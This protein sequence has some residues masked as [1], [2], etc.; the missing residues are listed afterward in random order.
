[1]DV[2]GLSWTLETQITGSVSPTISVVEE[3]LR[4]YSRGFSE[5]TKRAR[6]ADLR[7]YRR[8]CQKKGFV[9]IPASPEQIESFLWD[10]VATQELDDRDQPRFKK[11]GNPALV[12]IRSVATIERYLS[13]IKYLHDL[14]SEIQNEFTN[15]VP[16]TEIK[17]PVDSLLVKSAL[18]AIKREFRL[19]PQ[20]QAAPL[21]LEHIQTISEVLDTKGSLR[22][23]LYMTLISVAFDTLVRRSE[24]VRMELEHVTMNSAGDGVVKI[25]FSKTDQEGNGGVRYLSAASIELI[26][27]WCSAAGIESGLIFRSV[28]RYG[29]KS[30]KPDE[31]TKDV[32][33]VLSSMAEGRVARIYKAVGELCGFDVATLSGHST[34]VGSAQELLANGATLAGL[35]VEGGWK[36]ATMPVRYAAN[37]NASE[38]EMAKLS[39][40]RGR[41]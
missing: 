21:R 39:R 18:R 40:K 30:K 23:L 37:I 6:K 17:N 33:V 15:P 38:G 26:R 12:Q 27:D 36:S 9:T 31:Q 29:K 2:D 35:M 11:N 16:G 5:N 28:A 1:M 14:A 25:P 3:R 4:S 32:E 22:H 10:A 19:T 8:W 7:I 41:S 34:R 20:S 24:L 13:T